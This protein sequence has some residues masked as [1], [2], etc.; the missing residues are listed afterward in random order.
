MRQLQ[1]LKILPFD[2]SDCNA[3]LY[4][5]QRDS[6]DFEEKMR[7]RV[8]V[9]TTFDVN[10]EEYYLNLKQAGKLPKPI[11]ACSRGHLLLLQ[12]LLAV[13][14]GDEESGLVNEEGLAECVV[15]NHGFW[16]WK[17]LP[18]LWHVLQ[19]SSFPNSVSMRHVPCWMSM[20]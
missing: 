10:G 12:R 5:C 11:D 3:Y 18:I 14:Q 8:E 13:Y 20:N 4:R 16:P 15:Y 1:A 19:Q 17:E 2:P 6:P 7:G 9:G